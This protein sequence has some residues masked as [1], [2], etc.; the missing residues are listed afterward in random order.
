M[1]F[2]SWEAA[3]RPL[4]MGLLAYSALI[5]LL[6]VSGK[7]TLSKMNAFDLIVTVALG[8]TLATT[9]LNKNIALIEGVAAFLILIVLQYLV[10]WLSIRSRKFKE[11]IKS[12]PQLLF[13][14]GNYLKERIVEERVLEVEIL[15]AARSNGV[16]SMDQVE[17][18]VLETDG[19]ISIIK[20]SDSET[21]TLANVEQ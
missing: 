13:Y 15:Q 4:I 11:L 3:L 12:E 17:A 16:N 9:I 19:S 18:V 8:S 14:R 5:L 6:R 10:A 20:K 2:N 7:R 1:F 21:N